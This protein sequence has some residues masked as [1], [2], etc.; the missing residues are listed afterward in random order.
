MFKYFA[1][2]GNKHLLS[3]YCIH[4][5]QCHLLLW[6][7][8]SNEKLEKIFLLKLFVGDQLPLQTSKESGK[9]SKYQR[10]KN[11][12]LWMVTLVGTE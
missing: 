4:I 3:A 10:K 11:L 12:E 8:Q 1:P 2:P 7:N 5:Q 6:E 9:D